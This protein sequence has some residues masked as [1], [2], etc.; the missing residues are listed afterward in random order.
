MS[1]R[2]PLDEALSRRLAE[3]A[4]RHADSAAPAGLARVR[5]AARRRGAARTGAVAT[6]VA[7][8]A[9]GVP[10]VVFG[11]GAPDGDAV[12]PVVTPVPSPSAVDRQPEPGPTDPGPTTGTGAS[13]G[14]ATGSPTGATSPP[15]TGGGGGLPGTPATVHVPSAGAVLPVVGVDR[16]DVLNVRALPGPEADAVGSLPPTGEAV[17]TGRARD[18]EGARWVEVTTDGRTGWV[19][20]R[21]LALGAGTVEDATA[22]VVTNHGGT[23]TASAMA[24]LAR[25]VAD[26]L[27]GGTSVPRVTVAAGPTSGDPA[28]ITVDSLDLEDDS[29]YGYRLQVSAAA[30]GSSFTLLTVE[31][32]PLCA[33]GVTSDGLCV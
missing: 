7:A 6:T 23:P 9:V 18:V 3:V 8:L 13:T 33:R 17:A 15:A 27:A 24:D 22:R 20:G 5:R 28:E 11:P 31:A 1:E 29:V 16:D 12:T 2:N 21:F 30:D 32:T 19:A 26:A 10:A 4:D 25:I 14:D